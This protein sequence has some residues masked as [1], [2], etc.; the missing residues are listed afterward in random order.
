MPWEGKIFD[1][2][3]F[4]LAHYCKHYYKTCPGHR[5]K[6][7]HNTYAVPLGNYS[8]KGQVGDPMT[9]FLTFM[10]AN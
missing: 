3:N 10:T 9:T 5:R 1:I 4:R 8:L 7:P 6:A 2:L